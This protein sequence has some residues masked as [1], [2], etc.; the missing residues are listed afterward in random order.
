MGYII[1]KLFEVSDINAQVQG[2]VKEIEPLKEILPEA[3]FYEANLDSD[4]DRIYYQQVFRA[5]RTFYLGIQ[6]K[7]I[8]F[9]LYKVA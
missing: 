5:F 3:D 9:Y 2:L 6:N 1:P 7:L 4:I 8:F